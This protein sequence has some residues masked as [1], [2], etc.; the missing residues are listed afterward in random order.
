MPHLLHALKIHPDDNVVVA[1]VPLK[2]GQQIEVADQ[3][4]MVPRNLPIGAKLAIVPLPTGSKVLK[5][6]E[7]IGS[8]TADIAVGDYIHTHN[9]ASDYIPTPENGR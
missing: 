9:L 4:L 8:A 2:K 7:S 6:G 5:F 3:L 1:A